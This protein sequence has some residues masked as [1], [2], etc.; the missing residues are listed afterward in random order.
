MLPDRSDD[1]RYLDALLEQG[2]RRDLEYKRA[3]HSFGTDKAVS[4]CAGISNSG[5]GLLLFGVADDRTVHG[6][7]AF[8][9][10]RVLELR[11]HQKLS[12]SIAVK[13]LTYEGKRVLVVQI[14]RR[15]RGTPVA[16]DGRYYLRVGESLVDMTPH[17][18][19]E[20][21]DELRDRPGT[22]VVRAGLTGAEVEELLNIDQYFTLLQ[23]VRPSVLAEALSILESNGLVRGEA[24]SGKY[25]VTVTG[26][27]FLARDLST[28]NLEWR[29][30]RLIRYAGT[31][32]VNAVFE[33]LES[34]GYGVCFEEILELVKA[35][36]PVVEV[37]SDGLRTVK[38]IYP[39]TAI[40]EFL[41]NALVHQDLDERGVQIT[42]EI[43][44]DRIEIRNPGTP[45]I[46]V[47]RFVDDTRAR[48]P[49]LAE[50][51]RLARICEIRGSGVDRALLAIEDLIRPAPDFK[52]RENSTSIV[53]HK[54]RRFDEM[55]LD[56]RMWAAFL[57]ASVRY[58][59]GDSLT[60]SS[61]RARFGLPDG[62][63]AVVS[64]A[65]AAAVEI[66][67]LK[68]DP[69]AGASR[70]HARYLPFFA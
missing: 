43:F 6:T 52:A 7:A 57:H 2:E 29:R 39:G 66:N 12:I 42:V 30:I 35:H 48:N 59:A 46:D 17:Q 67:L 51:M 18:L 56:E 9:D 58:A 34:R 33:H 19:G 63:A 32:R 15:R 31:D 28:F 55:N 5:G 21:F 37:I 45:L 26:A 61:L 50:I 70:R 65:I 27:L 47:K 53:L 14:P 41:A 10:P 4:Y 64:Q 24:G 40:R 68:L 36:V 16:C 3:E 13:E 1:E 44:E 11:A 54:E 49:E 25:E 62:K 22:A 69:R 8:P 60:N 38:P 20:I 23:A